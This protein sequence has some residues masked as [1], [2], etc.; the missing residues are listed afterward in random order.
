V[1]RAR[2]VSRRLRQSATARDGQIPP[3]KCT[4][5]PVL[6]AATGLGALPILDGR[7]TVPSERPPPGDSVTTMEDIAKHTCDSVQ[8][9]HTHARIAV[10]EFP[11]TGATADRRILRQWRCLPILDSKRSSN[12]PFVRTRTAVTTRE[13]A[14]KVGPIRQ[15]IKRCFLYLGRGFDMPQQV[16]P[17]G[18]VRWWLARVCRW[19]SPGPPP[20]RR[21][22]MRRE[23]RGAPV[24]FEA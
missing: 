23:V 24:G 6:Q 4:S 1:T 10:P 13:S 16:P 22:V 9:I 11:A 19:N 12:P 15:S 14:V 2:L 20:H 17:D 21:C 5:V 3:T 18:R 7:H 8:E